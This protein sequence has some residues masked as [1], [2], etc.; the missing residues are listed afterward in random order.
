M[1]DYIQST[2]I[3]SYNKNGKTEV[4]NKIFDSIRALNKSF[5]EINNL[6]AK[7]EIWIDE[8]Y[9]SFTFQTEKSYNKALKVLYPTY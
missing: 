1:L 5:N 6:N 8:A 3:I 4:E 7:K 9:I 2:I